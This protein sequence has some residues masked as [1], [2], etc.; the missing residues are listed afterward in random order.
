MPL[1]APAFI[2]FPGY[3]LKYNQARST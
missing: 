2:I 3:L 1:L